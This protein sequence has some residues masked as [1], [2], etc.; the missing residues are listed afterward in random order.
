M[1]RRGDEAAR[2]SGS[3]L[4]STIAPLPS[5]LPRRPGRVIALLNQKGGA[6]EATLATR[7]AG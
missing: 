4:L 3:A 5:N 1:D 7:L 6:R 2:E